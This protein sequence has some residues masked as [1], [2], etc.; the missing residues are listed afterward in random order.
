MLVSFALLSGYGMFVSLS[1]FALLSPDDMSVSLSAFAELQL[2]K[3]NPFMFR[4]MTSLCFEMLRIGTNFTTDW[5]CLLT[6][7]VYVNFFLFRVS[8]DLPSSS[9]KFFRKVKKSKVRIRMRGH[10][11]TYFREI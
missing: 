6:C 7:F 11:L 8:R 5:W 4:S 1:A 2:L 9:L 10:S 3:L